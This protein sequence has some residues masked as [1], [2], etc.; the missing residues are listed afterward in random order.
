MKLSILSLLLTGA[1]AASAQAPAETGLLHVGA[2]VR[3]DWQNISYD[4]H[5]SD[6]MSGFRGKYFML[7][8]DGNLGSG[9]SYSWRQ[10][11]NKAH[12][13]QSFFDATDWAYVNYASGNWN[14]QAGKQM[15]YVGGWE[16]DR[17]PIDLYACSVF[18]NNVNAFEMGVSAS[19]ALSGHDNLMAQVCQS[20]FFTA[21]N[22]NMYAYNIMWTGSHGI[23]HPLW[24][25]NMIEYIP[26]H[27]INY[28]ALGNKFNF[29]SVSLELDMM[30]R[31]ASGQTF[32][33]KDCSVM[34]ELSWRPVENWTLWG[35]FTYDVN[36]SGT[37]SDMTVLDGTEMKMAAVGAEFYPL[38]SARHALRLHADVGYSWGKNTNSGDLWQNRTLQ[39]DAGIT[40]NMDFLNIKR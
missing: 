20:P 37:S 16:Y 21:T 8:A 15:V 29:G 32:L 27:W 14:F 1:L 25:V 13:D 9:F 17:R 38:K 19:Y 22:R 40:W 6:G 23:F 33:L 24:S 4:G 35:K 11:L 2:D 3:V 39:V 10:R 36:H 18:W 7:R 34:G 5:T 31:A 12:S 26:G 28:I 30:N